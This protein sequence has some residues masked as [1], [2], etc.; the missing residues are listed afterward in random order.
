MLAVLV[1]LNLAGCTGDTNDE[2]AAPPKASTS[3]PSKPAPAT[4]S[5]AEHIDGE[6]VTRAPKP[7]NGTVLLSAASRKGNAALPLKGRTGAGRLAIQVNC[8]GE[9]TMTV[10]VEPVGLSFPLKCVGYEVSST[11]NE[12][13]LKRARNEGSVHITAPSTIRWAL[14]VEQ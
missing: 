14:T 1:T 2:H 12:I 11:Y 6:S 4:T 9:G 5:R 10:A 7:V 3:V 13:S 8:Q